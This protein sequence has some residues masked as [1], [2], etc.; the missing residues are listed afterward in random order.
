MQLANDS[1]ETRRVFLKHANDP[2]YPKPLKV[3]ELLHQV[4]QIPLVAFA[5]VVDRNQKRY[6]GGPVRVSA[7]V[8][9]TMFTNYIHEHNCACWSSWEKA[10]VDFMEYER[11][12]EL[13]TIRA[14]ARPEAPPAP[15]EPVEKP[16]VAPRPMSP[17]ALVTFAAALAAET[18]YPVSD[19]LKEVLD[20]TKNL[21]A[22][23]SDSE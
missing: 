12:R 6:E 20:D 23:V 14:A 1:T 19:D 13:E 11:A 16:R 15:S 7:T 4:S 22:A 8:L 2:K 5:G 10:W 3:P 17:A 18:G 21:P 9:R